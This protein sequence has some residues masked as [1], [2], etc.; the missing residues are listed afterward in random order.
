[1]AS[2]DHLCII[3]LAQTK[4][5]DNTMLIVHVYIMLHLFIVKLHYMIVITS[6]L[7]VFRFKKI[8]TL[9]AKLCN[10]MN[11][12]GNNYISQTCS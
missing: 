9:L 8:F 6:C 4:C 7:C 3:T 1:M 2:P 12:D 10:S 11:I 5:S